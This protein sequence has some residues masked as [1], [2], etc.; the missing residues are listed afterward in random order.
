MEPLAVLV[1]VTLLLLGAGAVGVRWLRPW[2]MALRGGVAAMFVLTGLAHFDLPPGMRGEL[3]GMVPP[4]LPEPAL[5]V[6][7]T[8]ILELLG[9]AGLLWTR[10][11]PWAAGGLGALLVAMFPANV[12]LALTD[13]VLRFDDE[14]V[15]RAALQLIFIAATLVIVHRH[16]RAAGTRTSNSADL[17]SRTGAG[18]S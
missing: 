16:L 7:L 5:L 11:A 15:P 3:I 2:P 17:P 13:P 14:L 12:H 8:G 1:G 18:S 10:T 6:T 4:G 9:A